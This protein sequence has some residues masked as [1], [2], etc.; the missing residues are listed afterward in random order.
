MACM[1]EE[2]LGV[3]G[4]WSWGPWGPYSSFREVQGAPFPDPTRHL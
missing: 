4:H 2:E 3:H 1:E